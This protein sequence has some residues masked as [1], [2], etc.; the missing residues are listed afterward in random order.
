MVFVNH[1]YFYIWDSDWGGS[2]WKTNAY[3][4]YP[5]WLGSMFTKGDSAGSKD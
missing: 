3:S 4:P 2:F 5:V 1:F